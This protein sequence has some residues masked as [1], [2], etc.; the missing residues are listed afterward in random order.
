MKFL[1]DFFPVLLFFAVYF[2][3]ERHP[4]LAQDWAAQLLGG[5]VKDG[6]IPPDQ[7]AILLATALAI[8]AIAVQLV[9]MLALRKKIGLMQWATFVIFLGFGGATIYFHNDTFIKWKPTVLYWL[10]GLVLMVSQTFFDRNPIRSMMEPGGLTLPERVW[11]NLNLSWIGFFS[12]VGLVNLYVA[13]SFSR[14]TW[15][16]FKAFGLTGLTFAFAIVQALF[17]ARHM[18][19]DEAGASAEGADAK[20]S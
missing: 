7:A 4:P 12:V 2:V 3:G 10:F 11:R 19:R 20:G 9:V 16:S 6:V 1:T 18:P 8:V 5:I 13:F 14:D 17:L 15:V